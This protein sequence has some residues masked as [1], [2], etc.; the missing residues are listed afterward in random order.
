MTNTQP[1]L[2]QPS[3]E[4]KEAFLV[5]ADEMAADGHILGY[6]EQEDIT[7]FEQFIERVRGFSQGKYTPEG[8]VAHT[9]YWLKL[10]ND[11]I[12]EGDIRHDLNDHLRKEGGHIGYSIRPSFRGKGYGKLQLK[13]LLEKAKELGIDPV[14]ITC[15]STNI[16]SKRIIESNGGVLENEIEIGEGK[17][18]KLRYWIH[19]P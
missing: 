17:P 1:H 10:G 3:V 8:Y 6:R 15:D 13:L 12:G 7:Y 5:M 2:V 9:V 16:P 4:D 11:L 18:T 14:L 19:L